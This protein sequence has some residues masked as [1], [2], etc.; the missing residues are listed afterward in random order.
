MRSG[1]KVVESHV[2]FKA[3]LL[4][5]SPPRAVTTP[6]N[7]PNPLSAPRSDPS[8]N[9]SAPGIPAAPPHEAQ[10]ERVAPKPGE[11]HALVWRQS[12][13]ARVSAPSRAKYAS[14]CP[15][16]GRRGLLPRARATCPERRRPRRAPAPGS[17][18][19]PA[20]GV[21][22]GS[23]ARLPAAA[24]LLAAAPWAAAAFPPRD[25]TRASDL[26]RSAAP[27]TPRRPRHRSARGWCSRPTGRGEGRGLVGLQKVR[28]AAFPTRRPC[29]PARG[30]E[31]VHGDAATK[32]TCT[33]SPRWTHCR[34]GT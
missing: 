32:L 1:Q 24:A 15:L 34:R 27:C 5:T 23:P 2:V 30:L 7:Q 4:R 29:A 19:A 25:V 33:P 11:R 9:S 21:P 6:P 22:R 12:S 18:L 28:Q 16:P 10:R 8:G 20:A 14:F 26:G 13:A 31:G 17:R 3:H